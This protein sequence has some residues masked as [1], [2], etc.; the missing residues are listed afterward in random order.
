MR[1]HL[2]DAVPKGCCI[3]CYYARGKPC[4]CGCGGEHHGQGNKT[5]VTINNKQAIL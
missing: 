3:K 5:V 4:R 1:K 2:I